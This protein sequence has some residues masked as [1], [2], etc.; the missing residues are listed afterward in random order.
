[1]GNGKLNPSVVDAGPIIHLKEIGCLF[2]LKLFPTLHIPHAV[3]YETVGY[4]H[5]SGEEL[6]KLNNIKR[7]TVQKT[8]VDRFIKSHKFDDLDQ[9]ERECLY[10]CK[11]IN[12]PLILTDDLAVRDAAVRLGIVPAGS[13]GIVVKSYR[14]GEI[15]LS[16]AEDKLYALYEVSSLFV[17]K[18]IVDVAIENL[19]Q[20]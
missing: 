4:G 6:T 19:R 5:V 18:A 16:E 9:G 13:L 20:K 17:T 2:Y 1:M 15:S 3:W 7:H 14:V 12:V 10:L 11:K 8:A